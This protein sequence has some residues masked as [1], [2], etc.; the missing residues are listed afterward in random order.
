MQTNININ[1]ES[2]EN[3]DRFIIEHKDGKWV[4]SKDNLNNFI[5]FQEHKS[6]SSIWDM[7]VFLVV[8]V[9]IILIISYI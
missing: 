5:P 1:P 9:T 6:T 2:L 3:N 8:F 7:T 4:V